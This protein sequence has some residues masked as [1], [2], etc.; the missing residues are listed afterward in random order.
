MKRAMI[1]VG[2]IALTSWSAVRPAQAG[3]LTRCDLVN[4]TA[5]TPLQASEGATMSCSL[6]AAGTGTCVCRYTTGYPFHAAWDC[7]SLP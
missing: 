3:P 7:P 5:C 2:L 1:L 6:L 4:G